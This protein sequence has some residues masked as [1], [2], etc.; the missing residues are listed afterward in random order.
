MPLDAVGTEIP[1]GEAIDLVHELTRETGSHL[2]A[3]LSAYPVAATDGEFA[4]IL[5]AQVTLN[6][7]RD[8]KEFPEPLELPGPLHSRYK[9]TEVEMVTA[10]ERRAAE[11]LLARYSGIPD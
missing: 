10:E 1:F 3:N 8:T 9:A 4:T 7:A 5:H 6:G 2:Y 11:D